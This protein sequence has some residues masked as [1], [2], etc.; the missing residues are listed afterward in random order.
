M[1]TLPSM[2]RQRAGLRSPREAKVNEV[3]QKL[4][5][6]LI[7]QSMPEFKEQVKQ[8]VHEFVNFM[9]SKFPDSRQGTLAVAVY[10]ALFCD[11]WQISD[12]KTK[13]L[14]AKIGRMVYSELMG[15]D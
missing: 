9:E 6:N 1:N 13:E 8:H 15:R 11:G 12:P 14:I 2:A 10:L 4:I 7:S 3:E 5:E